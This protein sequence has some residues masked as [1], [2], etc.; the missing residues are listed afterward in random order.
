MYLQ[1]TDIKEEKW[2]K[3]W[4]A[5]GDEKKIVPEQQD[6]QEDTWF[7]TYTHAFLFSKAKEQIAKAKLFKWRRRCTSDLL[8]PMSFDS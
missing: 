5:Q 8:V 6:F 1:V 7:E 3:K 4:S 2:G